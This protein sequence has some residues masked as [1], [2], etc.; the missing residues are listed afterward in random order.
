MLHASSSFPPPAPAFALASVDPDAELLG[1]LVEAG[2][3]LLPV[4]DA[5]VTARPLASG[6]WL[7]MVPTGPSAARTRA[8]GLVLEA[9]SAA[10]H[11]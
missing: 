9:L 1:L 5:A 3:I 11:H 6:P 10:P 2:A 7:V 8:L 4:D